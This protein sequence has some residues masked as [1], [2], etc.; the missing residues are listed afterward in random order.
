M[1][2]AQDGLEASKVQLY[3]VKSL[4]LGSPGMIGMGA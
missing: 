3:M 4:K 2:K 1:G